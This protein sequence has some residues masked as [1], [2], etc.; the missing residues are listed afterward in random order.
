MKSTDY[1]LS[2]L[3]AVA[4]Y[5]DENADTLEI[6]PEYLNLFSVVDVDVPGY[7]VSP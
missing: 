5:M 1:S 3:R 7:A 4:R 6:R 2:V